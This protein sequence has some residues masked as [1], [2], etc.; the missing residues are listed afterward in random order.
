MRR[1]NLEV[2][3]VALSALAILIAWLF[4]VE[5]ELFETAVFSAI[6]VDSRYCSLT[7]ALLLR[8]S[9]AALLNVDDQQTASM[10]IGIKYG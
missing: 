7:P 3:L 10:F 8:A 9:K 5:W 6:S 4:I 2:I 1:F